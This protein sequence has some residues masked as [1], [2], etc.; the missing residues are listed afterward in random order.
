MVRTNQLQRSFK[1]KSKRASWLLKT[2]TGQESRAG[3][4]GALPRPALRGRAGV[5]G[6]GHVPAQQQLRQKPL[7]TAETEGDKLATAPLTSGRGAGVLRAACCQLKRRQLGPSWGPNTQGGAGPAGSEAPPPGDGHRFPTGSSGRLAVPQRHLQYALK[8]WVFFLFWSVFGQKHR[9]NSSHKN[10]SVKGGVST[11]EEVGADGAA[12]AVGWGCRGRGTGS[13]GRWRGAFS[14]THG[15]HPEA[16][17][18]LEG[19]G[20][21]TG[22]ERVR[23][24]RAQ[25][26]TPGRRKAGATGVNAGWRC[27]RG[28]ASRGLRTSCC[29]IYNCCRVSAS[30]GSLTGKETSGL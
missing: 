22:L 2:N 19:Q 14:D 17:S 16:G 27:G 3:Q 10:R 5:Q 30:K 28:P 18:G 21:G 11:A 15:H 13:S 4:E 23:L 24:T 29:V 7:P 6:C 9:G 8:T 12:S 25:S 26:W 20:P 1:K